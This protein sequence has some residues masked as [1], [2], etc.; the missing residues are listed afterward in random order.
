MKD[1]RRNMAVR[2]VLKNNYEGTAV[3]LFFLSNE[4]QD[5]NY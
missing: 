2:T 1:D 5:T 4:A 3:V